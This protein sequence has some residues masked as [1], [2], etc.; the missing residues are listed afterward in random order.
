MFA[1]WTL[2][3]IIYNNST[4]T[5]VF[6]SKEE[7]VKT[8]ELIK[9]QIPGNVETYCYE[10]TRIDVKQENF[11]KMLLVFL[12]MVFIAACKTTPE[13][14]GNDLF[15]ENKFNRSQFRAE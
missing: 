8:S 10:S 4:V 12:T 2:I 5:N 13:K 9:K 6:F 14:S 15:R 7:C 1:T 11:M 3:V